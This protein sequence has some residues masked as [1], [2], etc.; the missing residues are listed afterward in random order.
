MPFILTN[1]PILTQPLKTY[2]TVG[3]YLYAFWIMRLVLSFSQ[4]KLFSTISRIKIPVW[5]YL[6][7]FILAVCFVYTVGSEIIFAVVTVLLTY[8]FVSHRTYSITSLAT[9]LIFSTII[10]YLIMG[11]FG[12]LISGILSVLFP[13]SLMMLKHMLIVPMLLIEFGIAYWII[14]H[15]QRSIANYVKTVSRQA[16]VFTWIIDL[17]AFTFLIFKYAGQFEVTRLS[18]LQYCLVVIGYGLFLILVIRY[19][20]RYCHYRELVANQEA[21]IKGLQFYT[22][23]IEEMYDDLRRFRHDYKNILLSLGDAIK[24]GNIKAIQTIYEQTVIP[25]STPAESRTAVL[26]HLAN[27]NDLA[28]KSLVYSKTMSALK[29]GINVEIEVVD[30]V[31]IND[32]VAI[33]DV[34][35]MISI[36][37]DNAINAASQVPDGKINFSLF[38]QDGA[39]Y[40]IIGNSTKEARIPLQ[41]LQGG[42]NGL[43]NRQ[44][45]L[46]LRT[47]R[48]ILAGYPFIQHNQRSDQ[49]WLEQEIIIH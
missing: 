26:G 44:H 39:Q 12:N 9:N 19:G 8:Y 16:P 33:A 41:Q 1:L 20:Y 13:T 5:L 45:S 31:T 27:I 35:R 3:L 14:S 21:E 4:V 18:I 30:P 38:D 29:K 34:V 23:H 42:F 11:L 17:L 40:I 28:V 48:I 10:M 49:H 47:L 6:V 32:R 43:T 46:G 36:L 15:W 37:F 24:S 22:S 25:T 2:P 7:Y